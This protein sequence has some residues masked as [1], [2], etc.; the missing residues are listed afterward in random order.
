MAIKALSNAPVEGQSDS[1]DELLQKNALTTAGVIAGGV[2][3]TYG[4]IVLTT[5]LP[6]KVIGSVAATSALLI[7][8]DLQAK[9]KLELPKFGKKK[10]ETVTEEVTEVSAEA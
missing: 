2:T 4:A 5:A 9:G 10:E 8:G 1:I 6:I 3:F 7:A